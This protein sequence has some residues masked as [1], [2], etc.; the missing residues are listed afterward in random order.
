MFSGAEITEILERIGYDH[1][2][3]IPDSTFGAWESA[4]ESSQRLRLLRVCREGEAWPLAAGLLLGGRQPLVIMQ[5]TGFFESGDAL[6]NVIFDLQ[7]PVQAMIG[8]RNWLNPE[9]P[10]SA[11][12]FALPLVKAWGLNYA[13]IETFDEKNRLEQHLQNARQSETASVALI[14]EG[15]G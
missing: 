1:I 3:W 11:R 8:V 7:L 4:F 13:M 14:A 5:S 10:D 2:V 12:R 9:S 6:R 15:S